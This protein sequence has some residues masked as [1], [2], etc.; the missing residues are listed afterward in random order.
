MPYVR[1]R[2]KNIKRLILPTVP[3]EEDQAKGVTE[4]WVDMKNEISWGDKTDAQA[5]MMAVSMAD[6][7]D[8]PFEKSGSLMGVDPDSGKG[9][10][11]EFETA[12]YF[13]TLF[14][15][16]IVDWNLEDTSGHVMPIEPNS[17]KNLTEEDGEFLQREARKRIKVRPK[18]I[19]GPLGSNSH[20]T[21]S[22]REI[23]PSPTPSPS[24]S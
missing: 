24:E 12:A 14:S 17:M 15:A 23:F 6:I 11:T 20:H 2:S 13:H 21:S 7:N 9:I 4:Y 19:E 10:L 16:L 18:A 1:D 5:S 3:D 22:T 8:V